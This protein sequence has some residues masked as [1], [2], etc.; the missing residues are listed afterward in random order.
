VLVAGGCG[1]EEHLGVIRSEATVGDYVSSSC[2]TSV[3]IGLSK[4]VAE[5]VD[6]L[7]PGQ[8][9]EFEELG[10]IQF[11]GSAVLPY[12]SEEARDDLYAATSG[13][14]TFKINSAFRSVVQQYLLRSWFDQGRCG[15]SAAAQPGS[16]NHESGRALDVDNWFDWVDTLADHGWA[17]TVP[18]DEVHFDH[19][20]SPDIRGADVLAFQRLWNRNHAGDQIDEDGDY[21]PQTAARI[22]QA[23]AEGF[24]IGA[25]CMPPT[26]RALDVIDVVGPEAIAPGEHGTFTVNLRNIGTVGWSAAAVLT[27]ATGAPSVLADPTADPTS[28][29]TALDAEVAPGGDHPGVRRVGPA[30]DVATQLRAVRYDGG[31]EF[32]A[33]PIAVTVDP[34]DDFGDRAP[35]VTAAR[36]RRLLCGR[37]RSGG[38]VVAPALLGL[39][40]RRRRNGRGRLSSVHDA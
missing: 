29:V 15:I 18:G 40:T 35:T 7:M 24:P 3:V 4:Q 39:W 26:D 19:L 34:A 37:R 10:G 38:A 16:S 22:A 25:T 13:G 5:E 1:S 6:C 14:G 12:L 33:V 30:V 32:G 20:A 17:H 28:E 27:T 21:G 31:E 36:G 2:S 9:V 8:L 11:N 23:P